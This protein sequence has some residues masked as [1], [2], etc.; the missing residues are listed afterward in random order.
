M[1]KILFLASKY[2][3]IIGESYMDSWPRSWS[4]ISGVTLTSRSV[5]PWLAGPTA[6]WAGTYHFGKLIS[7]FMIISDINRIHLAHQFVL[8]KK[9]ISGK[10]N[11][12][13]RKPGSLVK[14]WNPN[15][16]R[17]ILTYFFLWFFLA[18]FTRGLENHVNLHPMVER[19]AES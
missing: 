8:E 19:I 10:F 11:S 12:R 18:C 16:S 9:E 15:Y 6:S 5:A 1:D 14:N 3:S 17:G 13:R 4:L 2:Y 7:A